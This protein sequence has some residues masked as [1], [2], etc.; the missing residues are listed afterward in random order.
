MVLKF[1]LAATEK[2]WAAFPVFVGCRTF[3][4]I[5]EQVVAGIFSPEIRVRMTQPGRLS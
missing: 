2:N 1:F 3:F 5:R 4:S